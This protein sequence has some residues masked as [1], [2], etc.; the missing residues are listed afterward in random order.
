MK[1]N[2]DSEIPR[3][4][5]PLAITYV[6][7]KKLEKVLYVTIIVFI[8]TKNDRNMSVREKACI[9]AETRGTE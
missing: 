8:D 7:L 4:S 1:R 3:F 2:G 6:F 9:A 5:G